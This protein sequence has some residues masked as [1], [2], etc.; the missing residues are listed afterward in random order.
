MSGNPLEV[1]D[2]LLG[3]DE[4]NTRRKRLTSLLK[5]PDTDT[6]LGWV[7]C[8]PKCFNAALGISQTTRKTHGKERL[9]WTQGAAFAFKTGD[10]LYDTPQAYGPWPEVLQSVN[11]AVQVSDATDA[12]P[13]QRDQP[14]NPGAVRATVFK[15]DKDRKALR[16]VKEVVLTQDGFV[17]FLITGE[18]PPEDAD[19]RE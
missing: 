19:R 7:M 3:E 4:K 1:L 13:Q 6:P 18:F 10:I 12:V 17:R 8:V 11:M 2:A 14:R 15:P 16:T 9:I 5:E